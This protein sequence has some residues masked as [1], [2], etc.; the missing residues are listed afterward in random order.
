MRDLLV[1][2]IGACVGAMAIGR[3]FGAILERDF[4]LYTTIFFGAVEAALAAALLGGWH[5]S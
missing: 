4:A 5:A 1:L 2:S 3:T